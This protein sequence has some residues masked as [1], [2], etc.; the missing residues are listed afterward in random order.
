M[1]NTQS[2]TL[3]N[4]THTNERKNKKMEQKMNVNGKN[5]VCV[6]K[7]NANITLASGEKLNV[8]ALDFRA[9]EN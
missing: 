9:L 3:K 8:E 7:T 5:F 1:I 2:Q 4:H 6:E